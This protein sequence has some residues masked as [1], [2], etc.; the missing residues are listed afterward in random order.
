LNRDFNGLAV[1]QRNLSLLVRAMELS[2]LFSKGNLEVMV[3][4][5]LT[6]VRSYPNPA[7]RP[8][9]DIDLLVR[10]RDMDRMKQALK[11]A[12]FSPTPLYPDLFEKD[13]LL[14]DVH[15]HPLNLDRIRSRRFL[16]PE[17]IAPLWRRAAPFFE[18]EKG[19]LL[20]P[21]PV[22]NFILLCAHA[23]KH[24]YSLEKWLVDL[25]ILMSK[26]WEDEAG[27]TELVRRSR[28]WRQER[29]VLYGLMLVEAML[30]EKIPRVVLLELGMDRLTAVEKR[31][32][33]LKAAGF[34]SDRL[35]MALWFYTIQGWGR[36]LRFLWESVF[37]R[38]AVMA[39]VRGRYAE[40]LRPADY[41]RRGG[42]AMRLA[43]CDAAAL[44]RALFTS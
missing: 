15:V 37:P 11:T 6:V 12:G 23:L 25:T 8:M 4:Q 27:W 41:L 33:R 38:R 9:E 31:I 30:G 10:R 39:Q 44:I 2:R 5:G 21:D 13:S 29:P 16:F 34:A 40:N 19:G 1:I 36:R 43:A 22:D 3:L 17:N 35:C 24:S 28:F 14:L 7:L 26:W 18:G 32:L 20:Q 42:Q